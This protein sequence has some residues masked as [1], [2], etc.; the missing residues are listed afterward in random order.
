MR[1]AG[2]GEVRVRGG[3]GL[4][5]VRRTIKLRR[6]DGDDELTVARGTS[7]R[8]VVALKLGWLPL[9][10]L[11]PTRL[12]YGGADPGRGPNTNAESTRMSVRTWRLS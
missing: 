5:E 10:G 2:E 1:D 4:G 6:I 3:L 9:Q 11:P 12:G 7:R 8:L